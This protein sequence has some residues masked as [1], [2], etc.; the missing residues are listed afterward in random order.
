MI[1]ADATEIGKLLVILYKYMCIQRSPGPLAGI[2]GS[3]EERGWKGKEERK[4]EDR[5]ERKGKEMGGKGLR[6]P[7]D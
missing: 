3:W 7:K 2:Q 5:R 1:D 4:G 6:P